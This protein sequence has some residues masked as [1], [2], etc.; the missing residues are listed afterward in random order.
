MRERVDGTD[1][2]GRPPAGGGGAEGGGASDPSI[3]ELARE[4]VRIFRATV[5]ER[6]QAGARRAAGDEPE[7]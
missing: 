6:R 7:A 1:L 5:A 3:L 4:L 2:K